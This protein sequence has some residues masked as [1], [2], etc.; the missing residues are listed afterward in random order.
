MPQAA[1]AHF[2]YALPPYTSSMHFL[3]ALPP[4]TSST[5]CTSSMHFLYM[6]FLY[7]LPWGVE[8]NRDFRAKNFHEPHPISTDFDES[9]DKR[10]GLIY[11][12][13]RNPWQPSKVMPEIPK[14]NSHRQT[15]TRT[16]AKHFQS[17]AGLNCLRQLNCKNNLPQTIFI[18][19]FAPVVYLE[20]ILDIFI[21]RLE[22]RTMD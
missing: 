9:G 6:H 13:R 22:V 3:H 4:C 14:F 21:R 19:C 18:I 7:I 8:L 2:L 12:S 11:L 17:G 20:K 16:N 5:V 10:S 15:D 1:P